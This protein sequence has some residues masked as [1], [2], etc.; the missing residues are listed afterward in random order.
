[1]EHMFSQALCADVALP[2]EGMP[3]QRVLVLAQ[4]LGLTLCLGFHE[5]A[6]FPDE[7]FLIIRSE[8]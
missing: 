8:R 5:R 2:G 6:V 7:L 1:M 4:A 3:R